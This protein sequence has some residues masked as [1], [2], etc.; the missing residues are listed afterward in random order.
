MSRTPPIPPDQRARPE[1]KAELDS[2]DMDR[3]D[4]RTDVATGQPGD[5][6]VNTDQQGRFGNLAQNLTPQHKTQAR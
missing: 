2:A 4:R 6:G 3:R 5:A 1:D